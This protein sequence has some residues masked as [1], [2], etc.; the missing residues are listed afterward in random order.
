MADKCKWTRHDIGADG[1]ST[2]CGRDFMLNDG[3]PEDN[4]MRFCCYC[5]RPVEQVE[6]ES[7]LDRE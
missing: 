7:N 2:D 6:S 3:T 1:W 5:G 4:G